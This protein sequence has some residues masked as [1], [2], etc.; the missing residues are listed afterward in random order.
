MEAIVPFFTATTHLW[1]E[2]DWMRLN[3]KWPDTAMHLAGS[4]MNSPCMGLGYFGRQ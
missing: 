3:W 2:R 4:S 1:Q